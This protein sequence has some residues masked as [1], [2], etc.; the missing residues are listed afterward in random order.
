MTASGDRN[1][2]GAETVPR[3]KGFSAHVYIGIMRRRPRIPRARFPEPPRWSG[4]SFVV[5]LIFHIAVIG[6]LV[7]QQSADPDRGTTTTGRR[8]RRTAGTPSRSESVAA[9]GAPGAANHT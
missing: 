1:I 4:R 6:A 8:H 3:G 2:L 9:S 5:S 7:W